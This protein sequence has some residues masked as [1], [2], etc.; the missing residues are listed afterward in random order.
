MISFW[1]DMISASQGTKSSNLRHK[2]LSSATLFLGNLELTLSSSYGDCSYDFLNITS[3]LEY[4][5]CILVTC[6]P[7]LFI[8]YDQRVEYKKNLYV[9]WII[10][11]I[12][13]QSMIIHK[14]LLNQ[15]SM[16]DEQSNFEG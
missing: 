1:S 12:S 10:L 16:R 6:C 7:D 2:A 15:L 5:M 9:L 4:H 8:G 11:S 3:G 13:I 14:V